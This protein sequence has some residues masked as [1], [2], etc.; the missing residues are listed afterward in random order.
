MACP[1]WYNLEVQ[2]ED[3]SSDLSGPRTHVLE[4]QGCN[5]RVRGQGMHM[6]GVGK[7]LPPSI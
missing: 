3:S 2:R 6:Q 4:A 7:L 5:T 1:R